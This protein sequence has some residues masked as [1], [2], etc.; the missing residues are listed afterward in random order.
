MDGPV[1]FLLVLVTEEPTRK[2]QGQGQDCPD[3]SD[4]QTDRQTDR[5]REREGEWKLMIRFAII[6]T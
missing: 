4:R 2:G 3:R 1:S 5:P 6:Q